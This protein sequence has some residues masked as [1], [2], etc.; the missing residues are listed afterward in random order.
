MN[1]WFKFN[2]ETFQFTKLFDPNIS[3][4]DLSNKKS[5]VISTSSKNFKNRLASTFSNDDVYLH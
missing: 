3:L 5:S 2:F 1:F 4:N